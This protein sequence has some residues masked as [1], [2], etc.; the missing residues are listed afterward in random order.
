[1][2]S[3]RTALGPSQLDE[4]SQ[5][6][7]ALLFARFPELERHI[8]GMQEFGEALSFLDDIFA[9]RIVVIS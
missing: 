8:I 1:M 9:E 7:A 3:P 6:F 4:F 2:V 5:R